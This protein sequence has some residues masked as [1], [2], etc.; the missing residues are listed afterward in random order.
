M[1]GVLRGWIGEECGGRLRRQ[2]ACDGRGY[3]RT[4]V[5]GVYVRAGP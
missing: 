5:S 1:A 2:S 4:A 3:A